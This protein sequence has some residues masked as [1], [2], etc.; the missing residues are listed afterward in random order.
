M[1]TEELKA[2]VLPDDYNQYDLSF[3]MLVIGESGV[4][5]SCLISKVVKGVFNDLYHET[6]GVYFLDFNVRID[7]TVIR[8]EIFDVSGKKLY[9]SLIS[10]FYRNV[11]LAMMV[12][13]INSKESFI[14]IE[15]WLKEVK[16]FS[17]P[18]VKIF[19]IGNKVDLEEDR[20]VAS[21]EAKQFKD[22][23]GI[24]FFSEASAKSGLN[25]QEVFVEAAKLLYSK[26][27]KLKQK[28]K[29][30]AKNKGDR[31]PGFN[32]KL[33]KNFPTLTK[34]MNI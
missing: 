4:G 14:H 28:V 12:Y 27:F 21:E 13:A 9:R 1:S 24:H 3:K 29:E 16:L 15:T 32:D 7:G 30:K 18:D 33:Y 26:Y 20:Q 5:K 6:E 8:L 34:W 23:N 2:E 22:E 17:N 25:A 11:K 31:K 10:N 19:L